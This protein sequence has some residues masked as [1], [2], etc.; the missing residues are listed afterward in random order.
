MYVHNQNGTKAISETGTKVIGG[1]ATYRAT[2]QGVNHGRG[3]L[4]KCRHRYAWRVVYLERGQKLVGVRGT[5]W[6]QREA[7]RYVWKVH[8]CRER[9]AGVLWKFVGCGQ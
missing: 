2:L 5:S 8:R 9:L 4:W 6:V 1:R 3:R 7:F